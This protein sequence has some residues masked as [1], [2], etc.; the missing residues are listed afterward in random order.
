MSQDSDSI[1]SSLERARV[2]L[3]LA[4]DEIA[5]LPLGEERDSRLNAIATILVGRSDESLADAIRQCPDLALAKPIADTQ[6][7][8]PELDAISRLSE[9]DIAVIDRTLAANSTNTWLK[10]TRVLG[11]TLVE[12]R[13]KFP[14]ISLGFYAQRITALVHSGELE[15]QGDIEFLRLCELRLAQAKESAA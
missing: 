7:H 11:Y 5:L 8:P 9:S 4:L 2:A 3:S 15:A 13:S 6:L 10:A 14:G 12:L 1:A